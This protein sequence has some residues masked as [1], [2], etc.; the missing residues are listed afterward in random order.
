MGGAG[1]EDI[2]KGRN[3][4]RERRKVEKMR[5]KEMS[6][7][8]KKGDEER[9]KGGEGWEKRGE[10]CKKGEDFNLLSSPS[11][12]PNSKSV[13]EIWLKIDLDLYIMYILSEN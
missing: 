10:G 6:L 7:G 3:G 4:V 12:G 2:G 9:K 13:H 5:K 11:K 8:W 1:L